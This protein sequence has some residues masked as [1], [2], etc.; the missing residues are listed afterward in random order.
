MALDGRTGRA[1]A[2]ED[3]TATARA[4]RQ[5]ELDTL[6]IDVATRPT[7]HAQR[8]AAQLGARHIVLPRSAGAALADTIDRQIQA[9]DLS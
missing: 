9:R 7:R 8:L 4:W 6:V 3:E 2:R 5:L 1:A